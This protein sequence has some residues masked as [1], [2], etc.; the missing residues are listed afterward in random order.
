[1]GCGRTYE[2]FDAEIEVRQESITN[3]L[4]FAV[5]G[6]QR[7]PFGMCAECRKSGTQARTALRK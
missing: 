4:D 7:V 1:V 5:T 3:S 6:R 2:F